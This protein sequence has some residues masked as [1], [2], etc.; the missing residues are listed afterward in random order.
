MLVTLQE[1]VMASQRLPGGGRDSGL[2]TDSL[3]ESGLSNPESM[4][5]SELLL[6]RLLVR[7]SSMGALYVQG[8]WLI[9]TG[10]RE[11]VRG[12]YRMRLLFVRVWQSGQVLS[13]PRQPTR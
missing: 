3:L 9:D 1:V 10:G 5:L 2:T 13:S 4:L 11:R 12:R 6:S 8:L 7:G